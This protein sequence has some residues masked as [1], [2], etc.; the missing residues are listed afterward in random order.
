MD[1]SSTGKLGY[2]YEC[3]EETKKKKL[4]NHDLAISGFLLFVTTRNRSNLHNV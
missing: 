4:F 1:E 2:D 3:S